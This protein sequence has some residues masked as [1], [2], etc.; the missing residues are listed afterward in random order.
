MLVSTGTWTQNVV[1]GLGGGGEVTFE[2]TFKDGPLLLRSL[3]G[4][5]K[6]E[7]GDQANLSSSP[8]AAAC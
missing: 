7:F 3:L 8:H 5:T 2:Q 4:R 1:L 6:H